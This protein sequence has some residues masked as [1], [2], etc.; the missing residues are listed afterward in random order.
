MTKL[1]ESFEKMLHAENLLVDLMM[2]NYASV[3]LPLAQWVNEQHESGNRIIG[4]NG[5]QG[6]GKST[7]CKLLAMLLQ[8]GFGKSVAVLSL[9]DFYLTHYQRGELARQIH[10]LLQTR[11]VPGTHDI[12]LAVSVLTALKNDTSVSLPR[13]DKAQDD[14]LPEEQWQAVTQPV[15]IILFEG[16]CMGAL[17]QT[18]DQLHE[19]VNDLES[20]EDSQGI[21]RQYVNVKLAGDYQALFTMLDMLVM[22]K[23]PSFEKVYEWRA[24]QESVL[25]QGM[26]D[27]QLRR[28]IMHYQ[29]LTVFM[30]EEMPQRADRVLKIGD[31]HQIVM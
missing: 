22:L 12:A 13:F 6:S 14:R 10:P 18:D 31:D 15:D 25:H 17:P 5:A 2:Q 29:R 24:L 26:S 23:V 19:P 9:D 1:R 7:L 16:W 27:T 3:Y 11:G 4:L 28:F 21:W 20:Q 30:L 8:Q